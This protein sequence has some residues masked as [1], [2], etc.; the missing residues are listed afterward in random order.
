MIK[1]IYTAAV[2]VGIL[3]LS[4]CGT[5]PTDTTNY[6]EMGREHALAAKAVLVQQLL[7]AIQTKGTAGA[8]EFCSEKAIHLTD[9]I[10]QQQGVQIRRVSDQNRN[11]NNAANA[12]ELSYIQAAKAALAAQEAP[13]PQVAELNGK[14]V[15]YYPILTNAMCLQ[16][17]GQPGKDIE[18]ATLER[19]AE[20]YPQDRATGYGEQELRGIWVVEMGE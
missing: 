4:N 11:P 6:L 2:L 20:Y 13:Q 15:G 1:T 14:M 16:C 18:A 3:L 8:L 5:T 12:Q 17:H 19:L 9:S 7:T 10:S